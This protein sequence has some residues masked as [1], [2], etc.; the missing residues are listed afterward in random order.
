MG[1]V[2]TPVLSITPS[3]LGLSLPSRVGTRFLDLQSPLPVADASILRCHP[4][5]V[6]PSRILLTPPVIVHYTK[7]RYAR[8]ALYVR[9]TT[10]PFPACINDVDGKTRPLR[11]PSIECGQALGKILK[12]LSVAEA[13][14]S[15]IFHDP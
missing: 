7:G 5:V 12:Q 15:R 8:G 11:A 6:L 4:L 3:K 10:A 2:T 9:E 1:V 14:D 13:T